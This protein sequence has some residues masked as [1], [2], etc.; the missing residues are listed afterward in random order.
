M[1]SRLITNDR[2]RDRE[3]H[4]GGQDGETRR[5]TGQGSGGNEESQVIS[6]KAGTGQGREKKTERQVFCSL[7]SLYI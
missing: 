2:K 4:R 3:E 6:H 5:L 7:S 1:P